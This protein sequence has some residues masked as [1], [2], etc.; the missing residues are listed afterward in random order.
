M[1]SAFRVRV[2]GLVV[3]WGVHNFGFHCSG[4]REYNTTIMFLFALRGVYSWYGKTKKHLSPTPFEPQDPA[5]PLPRRLLAR[6]SPG[7][8]SR[9]KNI[10]IVKTV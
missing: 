1:V 10:Y 6:A 8:S 2:W 3:G 7:A 9:T 5:N 4:L